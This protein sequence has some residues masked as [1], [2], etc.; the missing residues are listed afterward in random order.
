MIVKQIVELAK[1][2]GSKTIAEFVKNENIYKIVKE[3]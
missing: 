2:M 3:L 1:M